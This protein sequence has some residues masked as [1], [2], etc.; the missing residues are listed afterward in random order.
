MLILV[1]SDCTNFLSKDDPM[2]RRL[3]GLLLKVDKVCNELKKQNSLASLKGN[4]IAL[5][6]QTVHRVFL[7][8]LTCCQADKLEEKKFLK[9]FFFYCWPYSSFSHEFLYCESLSNSS[10]NN[11]CVTNAATIF[12]GQMLFSVAVIQRGGEG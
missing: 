8:F 3:S 9:Y 6:F 10:S 4:R 5:S 7:T 11:Y 12:L 2:G 1:T